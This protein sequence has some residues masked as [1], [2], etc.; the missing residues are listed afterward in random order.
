VTGRAGSIEGWVGQK[1]RWTYRCCACVLGSGPFRLITF[2]PKTRGLLNRCAVAFRNRKTIRLRGEFMN[3]ESAQWGS[4]DFFCL[5]FVLMLKIGKFT[6]RQGAWSAKAVA[7]YC[8]CSAALAAAL[9]CIVFCCEGPNWR[10][11]YLG[12]A[13]RSVSVLVLYGCG[14]PRRRS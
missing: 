12:P 2:R 6:E 5:G 10:L 7:P 1:A 13:V 9:V 8:R 3:S 14:P 4:S 11:Y